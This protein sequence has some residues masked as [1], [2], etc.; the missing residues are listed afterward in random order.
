MTTHEFETS[1]EWSKPSGAKQGALSAPGLPGLEVASPPVFGGVEAT[2]TPEHLFVASA[3]VCVMM[4]FLA[5]AEFS[6]L[7]L[8]AYRSDAMGRLE[9]VEGDGLQFTAIDIYPRIEVV[10]VSDVARAKR[11]LE[12]TEANCLVSNSMRTSVRV[13]PVFETSEA[14]QPRPAG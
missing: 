2:W 3:N 9:K 10:E 6:K 4:T 8:I 12:K 13:S 14:R 5:M 11:I 1:I 7:P